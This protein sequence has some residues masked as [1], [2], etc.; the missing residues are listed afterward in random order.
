[1][2]YITLSGVKYDFWGVIKLKRGT[3]LSIAIVI[4]SLSG[5]VTNVVRLESSQDRR[6]PL[7]STFKCRHQKT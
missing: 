6:E 1:M 2:V 5:K 4:V 7:S 3:T